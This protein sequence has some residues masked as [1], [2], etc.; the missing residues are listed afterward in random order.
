MSTPRDFYEVLGVSKESTTS[1]IKK[2][3]RKLALQYHPDRNPDNP[4]AEAKF[5]E[6][7][8]AYSVLSDS[9]KKAR[10]DQFGHAG[11][12]NGGGFGGGGFT[13]EDIFGQFGDIFSEF[14]GF[15]GGGGGGGR[16]ASNKR[17]GENLQYELELEFLEAIHGCE[18]TV[19]IPRMEICDACD[20]RKSQG[21]A[22]A[23]T[24]S[25]CN[26]NGSVI[27]QEMFL[28]VRTTCPKCR[29]EG[30]IISNPCKKC[31]GNGRVRKVNE[32]KVTVPPGVD[33][34]L[35]LRVPGKG[36]VGDP[37]A[38]VGDL[39]VVLVVE[40]HDHFR[41]EGE[42]IKLHYPISYP[43]ACLGATIKIPTVSGITDL[44]IPAGTPS[45]KVF[46]LVGHGAPR[47]GGSRG[48]G[49]QYVQVFITVPNKLSAEEE[50]LIRKLAEIQK[51]KVGDK[52]F[53]QNIQNLWDKWT[54]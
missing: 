39:F 18:K 50:E 1:E 25:M 10:Y 34:G 53:F 29:G 21:G 36:N 8:E 13:T 22:K 19:S 23:M 5:K 26:G 17:P 42:H 48:R 6:A 51:E 7:S 40:D 33:S 15:A 41:R 20:G 14:F 43:Q 54:T 3:Y 35:R 16:R 38:P 37:G 52:G 47:L 32:I 2:A 11:L 27:R 31:E 30:K 12:Q 46:R 4:E 24:C 45:G 28:R 49:D 44:E 9:E